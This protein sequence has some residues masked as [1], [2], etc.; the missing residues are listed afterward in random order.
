MKNR[1]IIYVLCLAVLNLGSP[2]VAQA[3]I[4]T[5]LQAVEATT[6]SHDVATVNAALAREEVRAQ[7]EALGVEPAQIES[8]VAALT[9]SELRSLATQM[10]DLPAG[11]DALAV[12]GIVF[13]VLLILEAVGVIDVFKK[14]PSPPAARSRDDRTW[15]GPC[16]VALHCRVGGHRVRLARPRARAATGRRPA[17]AHRARRDAVLSPGPI[18]VRPGRAR[19]GARGGRGGRAS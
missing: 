4:V 16:G 17:A 10:A 12:I 9:D 3:G 6:R 5:T 11:A 2:L 7:F 15:R 1:C 18:P 13:L 19:H 8:R 14:F